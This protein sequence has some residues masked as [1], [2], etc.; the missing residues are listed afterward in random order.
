MLELKEVLTAL[1]IEADP[2]KLTSDEFKTNID[3]KF[4]LRENVLKDE[5]IKKKFTGGVFGKLTTK[6]A[7]LFDLSKSEYDGKQ[8]E[9]ILSTVKERYDSKINELSK[10]A[11]EGNDKKVEDA[12]KKAAEYELKLQAAEDG[13]KTWEK[14]YNEETQNFGSKIKEFKLNDQLSK[15]RESLTPKFSDEYQKNELVKT[16][17]EAHISNTYVFDL[18]EKD[19]PIVKLKADGTPVKSKIKVGHFA[20]PEEILL[21]EMDA[22]GVLKKNNVKEKKIISTFANNNGGGK[23]K[24]HPNALRNA[25]R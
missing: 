21:A 24:V 17:F 6:T 22:K 8:Y 18:D 12:L 20:T 25:E 7:Q 10:R 19:E 13:L 9:E 16:G 23:S 15:V 11:G 5:D 4:V 14:K 1:G 2:E 3:S